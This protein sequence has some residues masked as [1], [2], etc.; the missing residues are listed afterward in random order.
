MFAF[1]RPLIN[2]SRHIATALILWYGG[3]QI[4]QDK[5][6]LGLFIVFISYMDRFF[7]PINNLSEKFNILQS[8]MAGAERIFDMLNEKTEDYREDK[9]S[10]LKLKG[11]IEFKNVWLKYNNEYVLKN[12]NLKIAPGEKIALVGH[13]GAGK[14]SIVNLLLGM[15]PYQKG[16]ILI[17]GLP[18]TA[19][20]TNDIRD[21]IGM[22]QQDVFLFSGTV[23]DNIVLNNNK[24]TQQ[25][26]ERVADYVNVRKF[27]ENLP[28]KF[29]EP[30]MERGA[31]FSVGQRQLIAFARVLAYNPA[32]FILDEATSNIDTETEVLIQDALIKI[33]KDRT[34]I[35]IAHRLSTIQNVD[36]IIVLHHGEIIEEG[37][38]WQLLEKKGL[39]YDL[40]NLQFS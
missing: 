39:Y 10:G 29:E 21:N 11:E 4:I 28:G 1:F 17:D 2:V 20:S 6:S 5:I 8:A 16:E 3:G 38:H 22:V 33:M 40:Y 13:T 35:I 31:T 27:I 32:I 34:S 25:E 9:K 24:I 19:F 14:T 7:E 30:V 12:I 36:R 37:N 15:Y 23:K 26:M 18:Q